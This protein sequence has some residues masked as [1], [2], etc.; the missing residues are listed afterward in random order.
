MFNELIWFVTEKDID[1]IYEKAKH[2]YKDIDEHDTKEKLLFILN[3]KNT[4]F[5]RT[6][7]A[8][9]SV[10]MSANPFNKKQI[11]AQDCFFFGRGSLELMKLAIA[12][13]R[14]QGATDFNFCLGPES[15]I[16]TLK[17]FAEL[18]GA[19]PLR[20]ELYNIKLR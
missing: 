14:T 18:L 12:W 7:R 11:I 10:V 5:I 15:K 6:E 4:F 3:S 8:V 1:W 9:V 16:K 13:A 17:K 20:V 2:Y 19:K